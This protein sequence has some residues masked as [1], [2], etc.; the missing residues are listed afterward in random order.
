M[1]EQALRDLGLNPNEVKVYL[2]LLPLEKAPA[3][4]LGYRTKLERTTA[5]YTCQQLV[6]KGVVGEFKQGK[7]SFYQ[8]ESPEKLLFLVEEAKEVLKEREAQIQRIMGQLK[9][10][11]NPKT[12]LPKVR[13]Y[14]GKEGVIK[15]YD[16]ILEIGKDLDS[17]EDGQDMAAFIPEYIPRFIQ[18]RKKRGIHNRVICPADTKTNK[19]S[20]KELRKTRTVP[21]KELPFSCDVKICGDQISLFSFQKG[22]EAGIAIR[23]QDLAENFRR[24]FEYN[25]KKLSEKD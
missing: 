23:H 24:L 15:L 14:E 12:V 5:R 3:S 10:M 6:K 18:E 16:Q 17:F 2:S 20:K 9:G 22:S 25:W 7:T 11:A 8:A 4:T 13:F 1:V 21:H 19:E